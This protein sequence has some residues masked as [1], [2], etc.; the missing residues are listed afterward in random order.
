MWADYFHGLVEELK[1]N[2]KMKK[3]L[4]VFCVGIVSGIVI[5]GSGDNMSHV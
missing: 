4:N 5:C 2:L 3:T 1:R